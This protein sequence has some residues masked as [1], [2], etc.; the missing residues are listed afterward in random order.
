MENLRFTLKFGK[1]S[2]YRAA[3]FYPKNEEEEEEIKESGFGRMLSDR[4]SDR[5]N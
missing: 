4:P 5:R 2:I 3:T 1:T